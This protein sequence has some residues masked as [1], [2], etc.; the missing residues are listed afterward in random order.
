MELIKPPFRK[1]HIGC[2]WKKFDGFVNID[3]AKEVKPDIVVDLE[4]GLP[5]ENDSFDYIYS[6]HVL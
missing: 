2:G 1:L 3:K 6:S 4:E 5:F